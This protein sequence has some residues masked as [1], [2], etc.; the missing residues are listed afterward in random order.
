MK[1]S[2]LLFFWAMASALCSQTT[3]A[4]TPS[5]LCIDNFSNPFRSETFVQHTNGF[6]TGIVTA[7]G[8]EAGELAQPIA[9]FNHQ[10]G[11]PVLFVGRTFENQNQNNQSGVYGGNRQMKFTR[12]S[13]NGNVR[14][15]SGNGVLSSEN[16]SIGNGTLVIHYGKASQPLDLD[17][18]TFPNAAFVLKNFNGVLASGNSVLVKITVTSGMNTTQRRTRTI[19]GSISAMGDV[20][21]STSNPAFHG[22]DWTDVDRITLSLI[23]SGSGGNMWQIGGFCLRSAPVVI[24]KTEVQPIAGLK[25][26]PIPASDLLHIELLGN[27]LD[28]TEVRLV[29]IQGRVVIEHLETAVSGVQSL[30]LDV[31]SLSNGLYTLTISQGDNAE[32]RRILVQH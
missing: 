4:Q 3:L 5:E 32:T 1:H 21:F 17:V 27:N 7:A 19:A 10:V 12:N 28:C 8:L 20:L 11:Q 9:P 6:I 25:V 31:A 13:P 29:D 24:P 22:I 14:M 18:S 16:S 15:F 23:N 2:T 30:A 26:Y